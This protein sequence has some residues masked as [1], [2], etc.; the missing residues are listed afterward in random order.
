M[1]ESCT[2]QG[3][4]IRRILRRQCV[5]QKHRQINKSYGQPVRREYHTHRMG[6]V[7]RL[8]FLARCCGI[9][10]MFAW[11]F[12]RSLW[13]V[14]PLSILGI[15]YGKS[16][17]GKLAAEDRRQLQLQFG[18]MLQA[19]SASMRAGYSV[20]NAVLESYRDMCLMHGENAMIC[21][22]LR[23]I[24]R[25]LEMNQPLEELLED[26][27]RRSHVEQ[28]REFATVFSIG[29][30]SSGNLSGIIQSTTEIMARQTQLREEVLTQTA[31]RRLE[32]TVMNGMPFAI[33]LY[34]ELTSP[35]YF[36]SLYHN[37]S[38]VVIMSGCLFLYLAA[39]LWSGRILERVPETED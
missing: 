22:E 30:H 5:G 17:L 11:F 4:P 18:D 9:V 25:G 19:V 7:Q 38:G 12:Y 33:L 37:L 3:F 15:L 23:L 20:E 21:L 14:L 29:Y 36:D 26:L 39:Y 35:G 24:R 2:E 27:G 31:A 34:I 13:A 28:I 32:S 8:L 6:G 1:S 10:F 16:Q